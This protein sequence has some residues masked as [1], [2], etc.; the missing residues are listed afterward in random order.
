MANDKKNDRPPKDLPVP[1][2]MTIAALLAELMPPGA[3][4]A[5]PAG[6]SEPSEDSGGLAAPALQ[7]EDLDD[8]EPTPAPFEPPVVIPDIRPT[9]AS[10]VTPVMLPPRQMPTP[11]ITATVVPAAKIEQPRVIVEPTPP[12]LPPTPVPPPVPALTAV[13]PSEQAWGEF[14]SN[15]NWTNVPTRPE[16]PKAAP[17]PPAPEPDK[18]VTTSLDPDLIPIGNLAASG[19][20][21]IVNWRNEPER[22]KHPRRADFGLDEQ[23]LA[24]ARKNPFYVVGQ[25]RRAEHATVADVL[26]EIGW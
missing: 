12:P 7:I 22:A 15:A 18:P 23:T 10:V 11:R 21:T 1:E 2:T 6:T 13:T 16:P 5:K 17:P 24:V 20:F 14:I 4:S 26:S 25:P 9:T 3:R 8:F 19:Y